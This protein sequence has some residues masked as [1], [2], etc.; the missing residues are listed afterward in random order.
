MNYTP[1]GC[2]LLGVLRKE[3]GKRIH[4]EDVNR[5][6]DSIRYRGSDKGSG[7]AIFDLNGNNYYKLKVFYNGEKEELDS[8]LE[9][10]N[11]KPR[12]S[13][14]E[15]NSGTASYCYDIGLGNT[16]YIDEVN[17][18]L[19]SEGTGRIYSSGT[20]LNVF[21]G[22]GYP[23]DVATEYGLKEKS[24]DMWLGHTR[25]PTNSPGNEP[26]WSH[27]FSTFNIAIVHNGDISSFGANR[28]FLKSHG[29]KSFVGTDSEVI[30]YIFRELI[31]KYDLIT[32]LKIMSNQIEDPNLK[33]ANRGYVL[34]GPFTV[35]IGYDSGDDLYIMAIADRS[36]LRP[37]I[38]GEDCNS[39]YIASEEKEIRIL[40]KNP[41]IWTLEPGSFFIASMKKGIISYG[42]KKIDNEDI[43]VQARPDFDAS[44][45]EYNALDDNI[46]KY[47][48][49][50]IIISGISGHKYAGMKFTS[51]KYKL[52][53]YGN[54]G[55]CLMNL[56]HN[57]DVTVYGNV[58]DD[59]CDSMSGGIVRIHG[60]AGDI[61]G[62][63]LTGG[64][65]YISGSAGNRAGIQLRA[66]KDDKPTI[67]IGGKFDDYLGEYMSGG[68]IL[69]LGNGSQQYGQHI[70]SGMIGGTIYIADRVPPE[71]I[72]LQPDIAATINILHALNENNAI[73]GKTFNKLSGK[74]LLEIVNM[75]PPDSLKPVFRL[76]NK[77]EIPKV[78]YRYLLSEEK[79]I[80][81]EIINDYDSEMK[82]DNKNKISMKFTII[83]RRN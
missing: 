69:V 82:T 46:I 75:L 8:I 38:L 71:N 77:H 52:K 44:G 39:Y 68:T 70:A 40:S 65:I 60:N 50:N 6:L 73:D 29:I 59:C 63:A 76:I 37:V 11:V 74:T 22:I 12:S 41:K 53:L 61:L 79:R 67:V 66:Y 20:S 13:I 31:K 57:N 78:S 43:S 15:S 49:K 10:A 64:K 2:G 17:E 80:I 21:K 19:W 83:E 51:G 24:G 26:Y 72:G 7:Y 25:Q 14:R 36:K 16:D 9:S 32:A 1:S 3:N 34:D 58:A 28:E 42:R 62:Q 45:I 48:K 5:S 47:G 4:G 35:A 54:P 55:N 23:D 56:N 81:K 27:P 18:K 30:S 33:Y